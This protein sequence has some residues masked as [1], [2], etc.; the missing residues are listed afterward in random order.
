M[1]I[2]DMVGHNTPVDKE[3][4]SE[5]P[6]EGYRNVYCYGHPTIKASCMTF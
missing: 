6:D 3:S 1:K 4:F 2:T 5:F